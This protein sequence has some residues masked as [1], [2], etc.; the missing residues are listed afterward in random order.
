M[1]NEPTEGSPKRRAENTNNLPRR[2]RSGLLIPVGRDSEYSDVLLL[3]L[4]NLLLRRADPVVTGVVGC[5]PRQAATTTAVNL[6]FRPADHDRD[7]GREAL[8]C[9]S[10]MPK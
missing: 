10:S 7:H 5:L 8:T 6:A 9:D 3:S 2:C 1:P 4:D